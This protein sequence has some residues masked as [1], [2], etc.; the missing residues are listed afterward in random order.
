MCPLHFELVGQKYLFF[1][2]YFQ[3]GM[4]MSVHVSIL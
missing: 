1:K 3:F 2:I 4:R